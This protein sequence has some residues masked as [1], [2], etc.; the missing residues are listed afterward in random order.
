MARKHLQGNLFEELTWRDI[1]DWAGSKIVSRGKSYQRGRRVQELSRLKSGGIVAWV[2]GSER[3]AT[4]VTCETG[5]LVSDCTCPYGATCKH[6]VAVVLEYLD[7]LKNNINVPK[8]TTPDRRLE[9]LEAGSE[10]ETWDEDDEENLDRFSP[11]THEKVVSHDSSSFLK[12][13][14]NEQLITLIEDLVGRHPAV[15]KDLHDR[16]NLSEG[17]IKKMVRSIQ[18]EIR[19]LS[20]EPGWTNHWNNEGYIPDYSQVKDRLKALLAQGHADEVL[21]LGKELLELGTRQI[22]ISNDEGETAGEIASCMEIIFQALP[23]SSL[24]PVEKMLWAVETELNDQYE[25]CYGAE[26]FWKRKYSVA[27]WNALAEKLTERL[28]QFRP[29]SDR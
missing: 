13:Q 4:R 3:Y 22:E 15:R 17:N 14:T 24:P 21:M 8:A 29:A 26:F 20:S 12:K 16:Q 25:L 10:Y 23:Q 2:Q 1:E 18:K 11:K 5:K 7:C 28:N 6:A 27:D 19:E 9:L